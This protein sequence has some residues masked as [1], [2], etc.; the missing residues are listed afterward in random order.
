MRL[1]RPVWLGL[2]LGLVGCSG[3][4]LVW[5][6][7]NDPPALAE[8]QAAGLLIGP[9]NAP[10]ERVL[11]LNYGPRGCRKCR[12]LLEEVLT[13]WRQEVE[14]GRLR[15]RVI[16]G[17]NGKPLGGLF[18]LA[19]QG[20]VWDALEGLRQDRMP[21]ECPL[22]AAERQA[23]ETL[24]ARTTA[25]PGAALLVYSGKSLREAWALR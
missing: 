10:V 12:R 9:A 5:S 3:D 7:L 20:K 16:L 21:P 17:Q 13:G 1:F 14:G 24:L 23:E 22:D 11:I 19:I 2:L 15:L 18:C 25:A 6:R 4:A 8:V